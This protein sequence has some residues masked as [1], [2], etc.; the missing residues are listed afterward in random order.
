M[1]LPGVVAVAAPVTPPVGL[2][3]APVVAG[4]ARSGALVVAVPAA[5]VV[6]VPVALGP[7]DLEDQVCIV[8]HFILK[9][10]QII[11]YCD[12]ALFKD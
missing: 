10:Y 4:V 2:L 9:L 6:A 12:V 8:K 11:C 1:L 7:V 3:G 5:L